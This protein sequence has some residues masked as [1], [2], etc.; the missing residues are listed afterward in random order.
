MKIILFLTLILLSSST[1]AQR[2]QNVYLL[3][4][5]GR[6]IKIRDSADFIRI[7]REP[8][9]GKSYSSLQ[10]SPKWEPGIQDGRATRTSYTIPITFRLQ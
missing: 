9:E 2:R 7:V 5:D 1:F 8:E 4:N 6:E 3:K 10:L